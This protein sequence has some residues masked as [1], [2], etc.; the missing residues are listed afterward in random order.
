MPPCAAEEALREPRRSA[1][2]LIVFDALGLVVALYTA[3]AA[4]AGQVYAKSGPGGRMVSRED[5]P[6]YFW[7]VIAIYAALSVALIGVF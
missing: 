1:K 6:G 4:L 3:Y 2:G 7:I 5:S